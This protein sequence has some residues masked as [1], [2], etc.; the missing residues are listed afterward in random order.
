MTDYLTKINQLDYQLNNV[1]V[2]HQVLEIN[3]IIKAVKQKRVLLHAPAKLGFEPDELEELSELKSFSYQKKLVAIN[4]LLNSLRQF[5]SLK[6]GIWS[7]PNLATA[8]LIKNELKVNF[9]LEIMAG[10]AYWSKALAQINI[11]TTATDSLEW[12]KTSKTG[13]N[14]FFPVK[15]LAA[16]EAIKAYPEAN[17]IL[18]SWA[19]NFGK[20][21]LKVI[22]TWQ[23]YSAAHLLFIGERG[24]VTNSPAFWQNGNFI[25]NHKITAINHSFHSYDFI[26]ERIFEIK[27]Q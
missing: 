9:A 14:R 5:L 3:Q 21:D 8:Q 15:N 27:R 10:N 26:N 7:L 18:C 22:K 11:K 25:H 6:F 23:K 1:K 16:D 24:G 13:H 17:L 20:A 2:H 4:H 19:P 12:A